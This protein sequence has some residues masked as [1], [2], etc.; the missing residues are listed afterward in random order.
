[1]ITG[2]CS[3]SDLEV[4]VAQNLEVRGNEEYIYKREKKQVR[5][6]QEQKK[7]NAWEAMIFSC[8]S[9]GSFFDATCQQETKQHA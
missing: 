6:S 8:S 3:N 7:M 9:K 5:K 4:S 2:K 1:L